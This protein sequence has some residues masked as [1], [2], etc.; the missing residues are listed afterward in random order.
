MIDELLPDLSQTICAVSTPHGAGGIAVIRVCGPEAIVVVSRVWKGADLH[1]ADSHTAH[2]GHLVDHETG[3]ELD[4]CVATVFRAPRSYT[5]EDTVEISVHG[6]KWIQREAVALLTTKGGAR[7][8]SRGEYTRRALAHGR[9]DLAQ[10]EG[11]A[12]LIASSSR[13]AH[14][15]ALSQMKGSVTEALSRLREKLIKLAALIELEL[16]FSEEDVEFVDREELASLAS[17]ILTEVNHLRDSYARG[18]A[19]KD[20]IP[21]AIVGPTN[22]GKSS[23]LNVLLD[24]NRAI[25]SD[26]HGTTR[27]T[28]EETLEIGDYLFRFIDTAGLRDTDDPIEQIGIS[29]SRQAIETAHILIVMVDSL[30][31]DTRDDINRIIHETIP[32][33]ESSVRH[34]IIALNKIDLLP[35][36]SAIENIVNETSFD[37]ESAHA[38]A[39]IIPIS[40]KTNAGISLLTDQLLE[41]ASA[42]DSDQILITSQRQAQSL[43]DA[44]NALGNLLK[45][46]KSKSD[47]ASQDNEVKSDDSDNENLLSNYPLQTDLLAIHL[48]EAIHHLSSIT[49]PIT[50][51]DIL[52]TIFQS[53]CIGK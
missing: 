6:S 31:V 51:P 36:P 23:L 33:V 14:R 47:F 24:D 13:A 12:D 26:I 8:A 2:L 7:V 11:V 3:D 15:I 43:A 50:T 53:F 29:R 10:A 45:G 32:T 52:N 19:I 17:E 22:A 16:D 34:I 37:N 30:T 42:T 27:D 1:K 28:I 49:D 41:I 35:T 18:N 46:L 39:R 48:R 9:L 25:V 5:G 4:Q 21:V 20:G 40:T 38:D 44:S